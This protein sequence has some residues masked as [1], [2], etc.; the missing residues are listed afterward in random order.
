VAAWHAARD[1]VL[2]ALDDPE[3]CARQFDGPMGRT[4]IEEMVGRFGIAD[5]VVHTWDLAR[6]TGQDEEL[7]TDEV[8]RAF[9]LM[10]PNDE[11]MRKG[12]AFGARIEVPDDA[13]D[14]TRLIAFTGRRP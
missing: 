2:S 10:E 9:A 6:A 12:D 4:T 11:M 1:A 7:D 14:Q 8:R 3:V 5:L 13:D